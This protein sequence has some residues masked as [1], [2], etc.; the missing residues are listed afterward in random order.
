MPKVGQR[1]FAYNKKGHAAAQKVAKRTGQK[2]QYKR[3]GGV[4]RKR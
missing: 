3:S 4:A 1:H 2:V